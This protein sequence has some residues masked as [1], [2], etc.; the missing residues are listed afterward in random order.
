MTDREPFEINFSEAKKIPTRLLN[1]STGEPRETERL[2]NLWGF[3]AP[4]THTNSS[5]PCALGTILHFYGIGWNHLP[6]EKNGRPIN[7]PFIEEVMRWSQ[8][9]NLLTGSLGTSPSKMIRSLQKA[10]LNANWYANNSK[11]ET[12]R[13]IKD[14]IH[15]GR[16]VIALINYGGSE[17][18][19]LLEWQ[20][21]FQL[22][23]STVR[24]KHCASSNADKLWQIDEFVQSLETDLTELNRSII[25]IQKAA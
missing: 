8:T 24:T 17:H 4:T 3:A 5:G 10:E 2:D 20:V 19:L 14:E 1:T 16:P 15:V 9:P 21:V 25:T 11:E 23:D 6:R 12:L 7:D 13:L 18:P 22:Q